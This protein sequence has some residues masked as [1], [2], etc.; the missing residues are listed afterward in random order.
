[1]SSDYGIYLI[2][3]LILVIVFFLIVLLARKRFNKRKYKIEKI[4]TID[5]GTIGIFFDRDRNLTV[6]PYAKDKYGQGRATGELVFLNSPYTE[7][8]LGQAVRRAMLQSIEGKPCK[9]D[10]LIP[11]L[12]SKNW[13]E[14]SEGKKNISAYY[15]KEHGIVFNTTSRRLDGSYQFNHFGLEK[16]V[17]NDVNDKDL[18][19]LI[20][21]L[22]KRC[23]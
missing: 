15:K 1:M 23:R 19:L 16:T 12:G 9:D 20:L 17:S 3:I 14:F 4:E 7:I 5:G 11:K 6:I 8:K 2:Y 18:G 10:E 22:L 21:E 13:K